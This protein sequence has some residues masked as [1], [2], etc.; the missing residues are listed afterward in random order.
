MNGHIQTEV[1]VEATHPEHGVRSTTSDDWGTWEL[2][3][4]PGTWEIVM[5]HSCWSFG[6]GEEGEV[7]EL[8]CE[9]AVLDVDVVYCWN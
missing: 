4:E 6:Y 5:D 3:L 8:D 7:V 9:G 2:E 1:G